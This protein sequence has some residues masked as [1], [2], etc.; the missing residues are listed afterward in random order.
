MSRNNP[1]LYIVI[2]CY[3]EEQVLPHTNPMFVGENRGAC[4]KSRDSSTKQGHVCE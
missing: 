4:E 2:P 1:I 3:N